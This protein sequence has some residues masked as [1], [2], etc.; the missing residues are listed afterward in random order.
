M[1]IQWCSRRSAAG[2]GWMVNRKEGNQ[3][4]AVAEGRRLLNEYPNRKNRRSLVVNEL[5]EQKQ[6]S[7]DDSTNVQVGHVIIHQHGLTIKDVKE[8]ALDLFRNNFEELSRVAT[9]TARTR[10]EEITDEFLNQ[11]RARNP[12]GV[13]KAETPQFQLDL[14]TVQKEYVRTGD[15][16]LG[17]LLVDLL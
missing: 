10:A 4:P 7:G 15:K 6:K 1:V 14:L 5:V 16:D 9:S 2:I 8:I 13:T 3:N 12:S 11:L 17:K